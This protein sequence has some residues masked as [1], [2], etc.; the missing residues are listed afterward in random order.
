VIQVRRSSYIEDISL[1]VS[2]TP[3]HAKISYGSDEI[4]Y[5]LSSHE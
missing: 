4:C 2:N 5:R 1:N 3:K